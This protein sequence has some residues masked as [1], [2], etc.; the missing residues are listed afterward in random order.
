MPRKPLPLPPRKKVIRSLLQAPE[1]CEAIAQ[2]AR[3]A[4]TTDRQVRKR[5]ERILRQMVSDYH[6][7]WLAVAYRG[8]KW[9]LKRMF[10]E[11]RIDREGLERIRS[12][13]RDNPVVLIPCHK[14]HVDY[15]LLSMIFYENG[16]TPPHI[17]AGIN[18]SFFPLG[19]FFRSTGAFFMR[20]SV[21]GERLYTRL[22]SSYIH[23]LIRNKVT[24]EFFFEG[25][26]T[27]TGK[28]VLP[29][30]G[31]LTLEVDSFLEGASEDLLVVPT[32]I[33]Y[34]RAPED[35][36]YQAEL[37]GRAKQKETV[38]T[39]W[40]SRKL[41][42]RSHGAAYVRFSKPISL[43]EYFSAPGIRK[44]I[45]LKK[46]RTTALAHEIARAISSETVVTPTALLST[47]LLAESGG[48]FRPDTLKTRLAS[49]RDLFAALG[50]PLAPETQQIENHLPKVLDFFERNGWL[51]R[52]AS[53]GGTFE[54]DPEK[55][56]LLD[57]YKNTTL[58]Y[59]LP[60]AVASILEGQ[61]SR[62]GSDETG[63]FLH[64][65][66]C[67]EFSW[68]KTESPETFLQKGIESLK[69]T[70][71]V[72]KPFLA[73]LLNNYLDSYRLAGTAAATKG[74]GFPLSPEALEQ[75]FSLGRELLQK[76]EIHY[77]EALSTSSLKS[78]LGYLRLKGLL[79]DRAALAT[80]LQRVTSLRQGTPYLFELIK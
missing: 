64:E 4:Q 27:R 57:F 45:K 39:L 10:T 63:R 31:L 7:R 5:A 62:T 70:P 30:T 55:R 53:D 67:R 41:L 20:R 59:L 11:L 56:L 43:K 32:A 40:R 25:G 26:R 37:S 15:L 13:L 72:E 51:R 44:S 61:R 19:K 58:Y 8:V 1:V 24:Q 22:L 38:W 9:L 17:A 75:V 79:R 14:S 60:A 77:R 80:W 36:A 16:L 21:L 34:D 2:A 49:L 69:Q 29:K 18:L 46:S 50:A 48:S 47:A 78:A 35:E 12:A 74:T 73:R 68:D 28:V 6:P 42:H 76:G 54:I 65:L 33:T 23:W 3:R 71:E 52:T 66:C